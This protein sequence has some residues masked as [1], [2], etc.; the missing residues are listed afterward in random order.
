MKTASAILLLPLFTAPLA[1]VDLKVDVN[2]RSGENNTPANTAGGFQAMAITSGATGAVAPGVVNSAT[3]GAQTVSIAGTGTHATAYDDRKRARPVNDTD[4]PASFTQEALLQD[5]VFATY[6]AAN[7]P[8]AGLDVTVSGL[9]PGGEYSVT[10]WSFDADS[11]GTRVSDW[12][13]N[14][15]VAEDDYTFD[16]GVAPTANQQYQINF[17]VTADDGGRIRIEARRDAASVGST[18]AASHGVF[19]NALWVRDLFVDSDGDGMADAW[20][21]THGLVVGAND[22][23]LDPD[24]DLLVNLGEHGAQTDPQDNDSDDDTLLDGYERG[25]GVFVSTG[26]TGTDPLDPDTDGDGL[27]DA[28][29]NPNLVFTPSG[30]PGTDPNLYDTDGDSFGDGTELAWPANTRDALAFPHPG[31]GGTLSV[32]F[33]NTALA[34]QPG[35][36]SLAGTGG[37]DAATVSAQIGAYHV[38]ITAAG[39]A[40]LQ[41]RDRAEAAGGGDFNPLFRDFIFAAGSDA[42]G[43]GL[44]VTVS[45][46]APLTAYPVSLWSWDPTSAG[47]GTPRRS[48]WLANDGDGD[49]TPVVPLYSLE[50]VAPPASQADR[51]MQFVAWSGSD[52]GLVIQGR[53]EPGYS[54][55]AINVFLNAM[56]I[57][58]PATGHPAIAI[59]SLGPVSPRGMRF[60]WTSHAGAV[61]EIEASPDLGSWIVLDG[62]VPGATGVTTFFDTTAPVGTTRRYY[63]I[64]QVP[65]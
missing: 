46:L 45:G 1:A 5:F 52:G 3:F 64:G 41:S 39:T 53:K 36:E 4:P 27:A 61:Y 17:T 22:A 28:D 30:F 7:N 16:G 15:E 54:G 18:G 29:E 50:G 21:Q 35:F 14:G 32:D 19:L 38:T 55:A 20:E 43:D 59:T 60:S 12:S 34:P 33:E 51:R 57:G 8:D 56:V 31:A 40:T 49:P 23:L 2:Q 44:D 65:R 24:D 25:T 58:A 62:A 9:E 26:N 13:A 48:T 37:T 42:D 11:A 47:T 6:D 63:R 10:V